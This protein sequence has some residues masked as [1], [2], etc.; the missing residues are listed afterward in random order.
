LQ[1]GRVSNEQSLVVMPGDD[2][3]SARIFGENNWGNNRLLTQIGPYVTRRGFYGVKVDAS[4]D[5]RVESVNMNIR[6]PSVV[7]KASVPS[8]L[9]YTYHKKVD[10]WYLSALEAHDVSQVRFSCRVG[11]SLLRYN[12]WYAALALDADGKTIWVGTVWGLTRIRPW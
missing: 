3:N 9:V 10:G 4:G 2:P 6:A 5:I 12:D 1:G 7:P 8:G 11:P